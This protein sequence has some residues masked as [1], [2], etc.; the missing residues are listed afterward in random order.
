MLSGISEDLPVYLKSKYSITNPPSPPRRPFKSVKPMLTQGV[1]SDSPTF[2]QL[3]HVG[4]V[5]DL[6][7]NKEI[8]GQDQHPERFLSS[9]KQNHLSIKPKFNYD[10]QFSDFDYHNLKPSKIIDLAADKSPKMKEMTKFRREFHTYLEKGFGRARGQCTIEAMQ[11]KVPRYQR[12]QIEMLKNKLSLT[13]KHENRT[14]VVS[15][16]FHLHQTVISFPSVYPGVRKNKSNQRRTS[17]PMSI[18]EIDE[19]EKK[20]LNQYFPVEA[21]K[22]YSMEDNR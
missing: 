5:N 15:E 21:R 14:R 9:L 6:I 10:S 22:M 11:P 12:G 3:S 8:S 7:R 18:K 17:T 1:S 13:L 20:Q 4:V 16:K 19:F 2:F